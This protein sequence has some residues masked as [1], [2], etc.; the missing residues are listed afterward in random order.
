MQAEP[1]AITTSFSRDLDHALPYV[2]LVPPFLFEIPNYPLIVMK[3]ILWKLFFLVME[4]LFWKLFFYCYGI[5]MLEGKPIFPRYG[6]FILEVIFSL[7]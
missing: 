7:F 6:T 3:H 2:Y 5:Y 1:T 4:C